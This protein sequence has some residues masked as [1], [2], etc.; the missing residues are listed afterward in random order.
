VSLLPDAW[1]DVTV[2]KFVH[3]RFVIDRP[4]FATYQR[5]QARV[6]DVLVTELDSWLSDPRD[7]ARAPQKLLDFVELATDGYFAL[8]A[9]APEWLPADPA[10]RAEAPGAGQRSA[11]RP[12]SAT[13]MRFGRAR[14][15]LD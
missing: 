3:T 8:R 15:I 13:L 11:G 12:G 9:D 7:G 14:G 4:D 10:E 1:H 6:L 5:G 2:L